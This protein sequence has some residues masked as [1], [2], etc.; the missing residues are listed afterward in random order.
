LVALPVVELPV[1]ALPVIALA[2]IA[3]SAGGPGLRVRVCRDAALGEGWLSAVL[4]GKREGGSARV[5]PIGRFAR[6]AAG[7][8]LAAPV[9]MGSAGE[10]PKVARGQAHCWRVPGRGEPFAN[11]VLGGFIARETGPR[12]DTVRPQAP[13]LIGIPVVDAPGDGRVCQPFAAPCA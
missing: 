7:G 5:R 11:R 12:V 1:V 3:L 2:A 10:A 6:I 13:A 9:V 8:V 4:G